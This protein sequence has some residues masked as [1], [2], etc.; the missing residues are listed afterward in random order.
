V[1]EIASIS[2]ELKDLKEAF[3]AQLDSILGTER[4]AILEKSI[5]SQ[6]QFDSDAGLSSAYLF[7]PQE[8]RVRFYK[9]N[10]GDAHI[11]IGVNIT[12]RVFHHRPMQLDEIP[13]NFQPVL[14]DWIS[15]GRS[16]PS[17]Q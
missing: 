16:K 1:F 13:S 10:P 5:P 8:H 17:N 11:I 14:Q 15:L 2:D 6:L 4:A 9:P 12:K 7:F 3:Y